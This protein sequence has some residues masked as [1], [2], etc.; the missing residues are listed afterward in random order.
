MSKIQLT[1]VDVNKLLN[2]FVSDKCSFKD[3]ELRYS[4][5][6]L[7]VHAKN[8]DLKTAADIE[9]GG[10]KIIA[11]ELKFNHEGADVDFSLG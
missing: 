7:V 8:I 4:C 6:D 3:G 5:E 11:K 10:L 9:T 2:R 1:G